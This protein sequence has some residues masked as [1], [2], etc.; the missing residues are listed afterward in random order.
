MI[1]AQG[2]AFVRF[3]TWRHDIHEPPAQ[4]DHDELSENDSRI[5]NPSGLALDWIDFD[6]QRA[7]RN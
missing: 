3:E 5:V 2:V 6:C 4:A 1:P 7:A